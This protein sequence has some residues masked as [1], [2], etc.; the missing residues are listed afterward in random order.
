[1]FYDLDE[2][3][4]FFKQIKSLLAKDGIW[5]IE[6]LYLPTMLTNLVYDQVCHEHVTYP[7]LTQIEWMTARAGLKI[8]DVDFNEM[9]GGSFLVIGSRDDSNYKTEIKKIRH[10]LNTEKSL[11][12]MEIYR[13]FEKRL[14]KHK[15]DTKKFF[16]IFNSKGKTVIGYGASTKGNIVLNYCG[17]GPVQLSAICDANSEKWD[18][19]T[20]G[21]HIPIISKA[22]MRKIN[23]D[24]L[25]V[26]I[27]HFHREVLEDE[28]EF[29]MN[30]G[31]IAF[32]L[33]RL[34]IV[35]KTNYEHHLYSGFS[36]YRFTI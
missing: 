19:I 31:K 35:D 16:N 30:G 13:R 24:Y 9:N 5:A 33:P 15:N 21:S 3:L 12:Q 29:V 2:P 28:R 23:P 20:P 14:K 11:Q 6:L 25:F 10:I 8:L 7:S 32:V 34:H 1:M 4:E 36:D 17:I 18:R 27:W 22:E 26:L